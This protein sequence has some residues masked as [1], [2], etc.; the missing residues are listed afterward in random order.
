MNCR[1]KTWLS[2]TIQPMSTQSKTHKPMPNQPTSDQAVSNRSLSD[3]PVPNQ[4]MRPTNASHALPILLQAD[5]STCCWEHTISSTGP[6]PTHLPTHH[7][8]CAGCAHRMAGGV[9]P[10][11][12]A[13][14]RIKTSPVSG[15]DSNGGYAPSLTSQQPLEYGSEPSSLCCVES[16]DLQL[17]SAVSDLLFTSTS[18]LFEYSPSTTLE[19]QEVCHKL[20]GP[21][22]T[23]HT[24]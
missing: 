1:V 19:P 9:V 7:M 6:P 14:L 11:G 16:F 13:A 22:A 24:V 5:R 15:G 8:P 2:C 18:V 3:R 4:H 21:F 12:L 20:Q 23:I 10:L 17:Q